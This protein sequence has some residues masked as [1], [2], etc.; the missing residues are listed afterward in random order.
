MHIMNNKY[1]Y[2]WKYP[3]HMNYGIHDNSMNSLSIWIIGNLLVLYF[4]LIIWKIDYVF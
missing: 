4:Y 2:V 1:I 3:F